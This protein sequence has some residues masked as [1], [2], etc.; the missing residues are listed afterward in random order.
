MEK[1]LSK[2]CGYP[3]CLR[4]APSPM[5]SEYQCGKCGKP[6]VPQVEEDYYGKSVAELYAREIN[7]K[8]NEVSYKIIDNRLDQEKTCTG[9]QK[10]IENW[11][12]EFRKIFS[13]LKAGNSFG[14]YKEDEYVTNEV[15]SFIQEKISQ[16]EEEAYDKGRTLLMEHPLFVADDGAVNIN[17]TIR[18][19]RQETVEKIKK[20]IEEINATYPRDGYQFI[21][22]LLQDKYIKK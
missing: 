22:S 15:R 9:H 18:L 16:F 14:K 11:E 6:F 13:Q 7:N 5:Y 21:L 4:E 19:V 1:H 8:R 2:C 10:N 3:K 12:D 20:E 17:E